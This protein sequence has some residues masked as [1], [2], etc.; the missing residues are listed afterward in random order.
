MV[1]SPLTVN[2]A[3]T[4]LGPAPIPNGQ[5]QGTSVPV[6]GRVTAIAVHPTN[7]NIVYAAVAQ[8]GVYRTLDGGSSW[9]PIFDDA[10]SL[11][12]GALAIAPSSPST[13]Y[14]GTGEANNSC[15][16]YAG[17]G[18]YRI[19]NADTTPSLVGPIDPQM[20]FTSA[21]D[22]SPVTVNIFRHLAIAK[23]VV[24]P[25]DAATVF[26]ATTFGIASIGCEFPFD[27]QFPPI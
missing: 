27:L 7:P 17:V 6:S 22:G 23:I 12:V 4:A 21:S 13:V 25:D 2:P 18:L 14:V 8:G 9:T 15:D 1:A 20:T 3:W 19:D 26:V 11:A 16:S 5:T 24:K 10:Q